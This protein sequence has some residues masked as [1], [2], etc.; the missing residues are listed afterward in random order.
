MDELPSMESMLGR[1]LHTTFSEEETSYAD[2]SKVDSNTG[3]RSQINHINNYYAAATKAMKHNFYD[4]PRREFEKLKE[5]TSIDQ[6]KTEHLSL[7]DK[8]ITAT[9]SH[10]N[11]YA[12]NN[13]Q[14]KERKKPKNPFTI[15]FSELAEVL[16]CG[17][18]DVPRQP[19]TKRFEEEKME[20]IEHLGSGSRC[21][22]VL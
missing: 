5:L 10:E 6:T 22:L 18:G 8:D 12:T 11:I 17:C 7:M 9:E 15:I 1:D 16:E 3:G 14:G 21:D 2:I 4:V 13:M 20:P 19:V